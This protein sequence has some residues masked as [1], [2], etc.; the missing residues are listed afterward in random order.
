MWCREL[1]EHPM[2][3]KQGE[4]QCSEDCQGAASSS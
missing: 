2:P 3:V 1:C 4:G